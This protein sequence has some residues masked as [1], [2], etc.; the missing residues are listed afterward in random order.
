MTD[1]RIDRD[2]AQRI[3]AQVLRDDGNVQPAKANELA[4]QM[5]G[6]LR[7]SM[8]RPSKPGLRGY[9]IID[10]RPPYEQSEAFIADVKKFLAAVDKRTAEKLWELVY[11]RGRDM[12]DDIAL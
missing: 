10:Y 6:R 9:R 11:N 5:C 1:L 4:S 3:I 2:K 7:T 12:P 8:A